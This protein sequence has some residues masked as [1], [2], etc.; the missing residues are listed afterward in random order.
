MHRRCLGLVSV[1]PRVVSSSAAVCE[2]RYTTQNSLL[3]FRNYLHHTCSAPLR[4]FSTNTSTP[5]RTFST[6][7]D[8]DS[9]STN[10]DINSPSTN[11]DIINNDI[12]SPP[13][14]KIKSEH[15]KKLESLPVTYSDISRAHIA[16]RSGI[17]RTPCIKSYFLSEVCSDFHRVSYIAIKICLILSE[18]LYS[19]LLSILYQTKSSYWVQTS[20]SRQNSN[21]LQAVSKKEEPGMLYSIFIARN[22]KGRANTKRRSNSS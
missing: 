16:I 2:S 11:D 4:T 17:K 6:T 12:L 9:S 21:N 22:G 18:Q 5:L 10:N 3:M 13:R 1:V 20:F 19:P 8:I 7:N 14:R 15:E